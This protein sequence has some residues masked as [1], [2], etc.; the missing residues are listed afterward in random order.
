MHTACHGSEDLLGVWF[1]FGLKWE[2]TMIFLKFF[3]KHPQKPDF[4][5]I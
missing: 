3:F 2:G 1:G 4:F 5:S